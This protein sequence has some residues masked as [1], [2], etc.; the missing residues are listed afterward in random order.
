MD[1]SENSG[2]P[3]SSILIGFSII[4]HP[5]YTHIGV[6]NS[7]HN[8][9]VGAYLA[10]APPPLCLTAWRRVQEH[11]CLKLSTKNVSIVGGFSINPSEKKICAMSNWKSSSPGMNNKNLWNHHLCMCVCVRK[12]A[13]SL[14]ESDDLWWECNIWFLGWRLWASKC[15]PSNYFCRCLLMTVYFLKIMFK[16]L[17]KSPLY[18]EKNTK[19]I[20]ILSNLL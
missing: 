14:Q 9:I 6:Y 16:S 8:R 20:Q 3:K 12:M 5:F 11:C 7:T 10:P 15:T 18:L 1:V 17:V 4:N 13:V 19:C 2:T